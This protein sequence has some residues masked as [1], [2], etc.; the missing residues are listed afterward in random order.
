M[1]TKISRFI[2]MILVLTVVLIPM[3]FDSASAATSA[4]HDYSREGSFYNTELTAADIIELVDAAYN[5]SEAEKAYLDKY[6]PFSF[7]YERLPDQDIVTDRDESRVTVSAK[8]YK[9]ISVSG[10]EVI[11]Y[12]VSARI[13]DAEASLVKNGDVYSAIFEGVP[14]DDELTAT[15][16]YK[17]S[18]SVSI[19][20]EDIN[21]L[22]R[23]AYE[24]A[25][26]V[27]DEYSNYIATKEVYDNFVA[28]HADAIKAYE[29]SVGKYQQYLSDKSTY[30]YKCSLYEANQAEWDK[31]NRDLQAYNDF[32][33]ASK[34]YRELVKLHDEYKDACDEYDKKLEEYNNYDKNMLIVKEQLNTLD[35]GLMGKV[36]YLERQIYS[37]VFSGLVSEVLSYE[38]VMQ[39]FA[40]DVDIEV[41]EDCGYATESLQSI[42]SKYNAIKDE[43]EKY[44]FYVSNY[45]RLKENVVL[46]AQ[47]LEA[48]YT[49]SFLINA[50]EMK[51]KTEK[52]VIFVSQMILFANAI[53]DEPIYNHRLSKKGN[54]V[55]DK[56][57][58]I[59]YKLNGKSY[60]KTALEILENN[61][62][63]KDTEN[64]APL[65][66]GYPVAIEKP[67]EPTPPQPLPDSPP[68][69]VSRPKIEPEHMDE[70][71]APDE[72]SEPEPFD[73]PFPEYAEPPEF[74]SD[75]VMMGLIASKDQLEQRAEYKT[76]FVYEIYETQTTKIGPKEYVYVT[77][78]NTDGTE[79]TKISVEK[80]K[81]VNYTDT[82]PTKEGNDSC[83]YKFA[84]W[85]T[86]DGTKYDLACIE[87]DISLYPCFTEI[88][89]VNVTFYD[90][91]RATELL[92]VK[93]EKNGSVEY[94]GSAPAKE[95]NI[96][97]DYEFDYW[98]TESGEKY[99]LSCIEDNIL[100]YPHF[101]E[102]Y[103][104][105]EITEDP[106]DNNKY[107]VVEYSA[108]DS[109][110]LPMQHF[111]SL[112]SSNNSGIKISVLNS[113]ISIHPSVV[114]E[115]KNNGVETLEYN[116]DLS[117]PT[118]YACQIS[119]KN[120]N[121]EK[122][123]TPMY[124]SISI[125]CTDAHFGENSIVTYVDRQGTVRMVSKSYAN[126]KMK[127]DMNTA[128]EYSVSEP[129]ID[130][131]EDLEYGLEF[132]T[133]DD[134]RFNIKLPEIAKAGTVITFD[135]T[136]VEGYS[137]E[138]SYYDA[139]MVK[140]IITGNSFV[141][142]ACDVEV[143]VKYSLLRFTVT[144]VN[145]GNVLSE[146]AYSYGEM[147]VPP[148]NVTKPSTTETK[149]TFVGWSEEISAVTGDI[150]YT[151]VY[152]DEAVTRVEKE[153]P[154]LVKLY[155][156]AKEI[157]AKVA[158]VT[159]IVA[160]SV[161]GTFAIAALVLTIVGN[162][163]YHM[164]LFVFI[165]F[166]FGK[167]FSKQP[168]T[169]ASSADAAENAE[170]KP[171]N[172]EKEAEDRVDLDK[173]E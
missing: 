110:E 83:E 173:T 138:F 117:D 53:T 149:Y 92:S 166:I 62:Y 94:T 171:K 72:V 96:V 146:R 11:W 148:S 68:A 52:Y 30:E 43:K 98:V 33:T 137:V 136:A 172:E 10:D 74:L 123:D 13:E 157:V 103:K 153:P 109:T 162:S 17:L 111:I 3:T 23:E 18:V 130:D 35:T 104:K 46:L 37:S 64:A 19:S 170:E 107:L 1:K 41:M 78:Y 152:K 168:K 39:D 66:K 126:G 2:C 27:A 32:V 129:V 141:M 112:A 150:T 102:I 131:P 120:A 90:S 20:M 50:I 80:N 71:I 34:A 36:T 40:K 143:T 5:V 31:Y 81:G 114:N 116:I 118:A 58:T 69:F 45:S 51:G 139:A 106:S 93:V 128:Y 67:T 161:L 48:F 124:I 73:P 26:A 49:D 135:F 140:Q 63:V 134:E 24:T 89:Y 97:L 61:E 70:P 4:V 144:F 91:D 155:T 59:T 159:G 167:I 122:I 154:K 169:D 160:V 15:V 65:P 151:A 164:S 16:K 163:V 79:I 85:A 75:D 95:G 113:D 76:D 55:L 25:P 12:P 14:P 7:K 6:L 121:N 44:E 105:H 119:A 127:F 28:E 132:N 156:R 57:T 158:K 38:P 100:L 101:A 86:S 8:E 84:Y 29:E 42:L 82:I 56:T 99:D 77:F 22:L 115:M 87:S 88:P 54:Y 133:V 125:P 142:P 147:P 21:K 47:C 145:D 165:G 60:T 9:Y 108:L